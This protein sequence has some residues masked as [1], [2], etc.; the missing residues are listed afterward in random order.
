MLAVEPL[1]DLFTLLGQLQQ[2]LAQNVNPQL[3]F[4]QLVLQLQQWFDVP[5]R[6]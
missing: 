3:A 4:E 1:L 2:Y 5:Q 6:A